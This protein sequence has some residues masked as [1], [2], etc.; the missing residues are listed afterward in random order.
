MLTGRGV[1]CTWP[2]RRARPSLLHNPNAFCT[3][4]WCEWLLP[5]KNRLMAEVPERCSWAVELQGD[6]NSLPHSR[7]LPPLKRR[8][9]SGV[10]NDLI[11]GHR[12]EA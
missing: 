1:N 10:S 5:S 4:K 2:R 6:A 7:S 12:G 9:S 11:L 3:L 8:L